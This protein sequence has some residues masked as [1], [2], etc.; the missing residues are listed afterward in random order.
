V[1]EPDDPE[2]GG[3][4]AGLPSTRPQRRSAKR[5]PAKGGST[6]ATAARARQTGG[7]AKAKSK[8]KSKDQPVARTASA[9]KSKTRARAKPTAPRAKATAKPTA[10]RAKATAK[11]TAPRAKATAEP[12]APRA[13]T[14]AET[15]HAG[16]PVAGDHAQ[17]AARGGGRPR[18][19]APLAAQ[20]FEPDT[21]SGPVE[22][23]SRTD[24]LGSIVEGAGDLA[25]VGLELTRQLL[26]AV[27]GR[28]PGP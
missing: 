8:T 18:E 28:L 22:P 26:R 7:S 2:T 12:T 11:P 9:S 14:T 27:L 4:L 20:G 6:A 13:K 21:A 1:D 24:V 5:D 3:V 10:P 23:P 16:P 15:A 25:R 17:R 19:Q